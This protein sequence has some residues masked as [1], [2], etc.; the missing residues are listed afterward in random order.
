[1]HFQRNVREIIS[2]ALQKFRVG[3]SKKAS[4][5]RL[6]KTVIRA[7]CCIS[8]SVYGQ[9]LLCL[10][11]SCCLECFLLSES[12][13]GCMLHVFVPPALSRSAAHL[14]TATPPPKLHLPPAPLFI[15]H[16]VVLLV[17]NAGFHSNAVFGKAHLLYGINKMFI[18][19]MK[20]AS[21]VVSLSL[22]MR[23]Q[24]PFGRERERERH[25]SVGS[26][27]SA[28]HFFNLKRRKTNLFLFSTNPGT[29]PCI[30]RRKPG[31]FSAP[32]PLG[33]FW[34]VLIAPWWKR[35]GPQ[36]CF[37]DRFTLFVSDWPCSSPEARQ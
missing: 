15:T 6:Q 37:L 29:S 13:Y 5:K 3:F 14:H 16:S 18:N 24:N 30:N 20:P 25:S 17:V 19:F 35:K 9:I 21:C 32:V 31:G 10:G 26:S 11:F 28:N 8:S 27:T 4:Q 23:L 22:C 33:L 36:K 12:C 2:I 1:M 34:G 7:I